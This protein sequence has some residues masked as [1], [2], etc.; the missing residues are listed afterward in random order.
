MRFQREV[1]VKH[2]LILHSL[3]EINEYSFSECREMSNFLN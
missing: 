1:I 2:L 3:D